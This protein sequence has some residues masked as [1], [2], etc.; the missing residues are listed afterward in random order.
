MENH[1][2]PDDL[3]AF[4]KAYNEISAATVK[5]HSVYISAEVRSKYLYRLLIS[6]FTLYTNYTYTYV[7][8]V[9]IY[10]IIFLYRMRPRQVPQCLTVSTASAS[11]Q[12][13]SSCPGCLICAPT[14]PTRLTPISSFI[15]ADNRLE[16]RCLLQLFI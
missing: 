11:A 4:V 9:T 5:P 16:Y 3:R 8:D 6:V 14:L 12:S 1:I 2:S 10:L 15:P 13:R 7:T